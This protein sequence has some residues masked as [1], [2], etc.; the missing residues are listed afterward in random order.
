M[1]CPAAPAEVS[2]RQLVGA[3]TPD[4]KNTAT[5]I[6]AIQPSGAIVAPAGVNTNNANKTL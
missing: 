4:C 3:T 5:A 1:A 2:G 6:T